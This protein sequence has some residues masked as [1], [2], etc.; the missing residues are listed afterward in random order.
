MRGKLALALCLITG[1]CALSNAAMAQDTRVSVT[2]TLTTEYRINNKNGNDQ[3]DD[4]G[5]M[6]NRFNLSGN[7]GDISTQLRL[8]TV[9]F[10]EE[11]G[12]PAPPEGLTFKDNARLERLTVTYDLGD[13]TLVAGDYFLQLG[14]GI[15]LSIR[16]VDEAGLDVAIRG[17]RVSWSGDEHEFMVF[18][19][20]TNTVNIDL[21]SQVF[22]EETNDLITGANYEYTG[23]DIANVGTFLMYFRPTQTLLPG[24]RDETVANGLYVN[25]PDLTD[26]LSLYVELGSQRQKLAGAVSTGR[27][28]GDTILANGF[29]HYTAANIDFYPLTFLVEGIWLDDYNIRGSQNTA[30]GSRFIYN[31]APTL[32]RFDQEV[33]QNNDVRGARVRAEYAVEEPDLVFHV[34]GLYRLNNVGDAEELQQVHVFGGFDINYGASRLGISGGIRDEQQTEGVFTKTIDHFEWDWLQVLGESEYSLHING[35]VWLRTLDEAEFTQGSSFFGIDK[36][37]LGGFTFEFG[38]DTQDPSPGVRN[39]FFAGILAWEISDEF[40]TRITG[41]TQRGGIKC[42]SGVCREF[43]AFAGGRMELIGRF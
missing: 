11:L 20:Q 43:P 13:W 33:L 38:Y 12:V 27:G 7:A 32:E 21:L 15:A 34:N 10:G 39:L 42:I 37:G 17:G 5:V 22:I 35:N 3:D 2:D 25:M 40:T 1:L 29:G 8:D 24:L 6:I 9:Y 31:L 36:A 26:W 28:V 41:G 23:L 30:L 14:R 4:F 16:K 18:A 19:G